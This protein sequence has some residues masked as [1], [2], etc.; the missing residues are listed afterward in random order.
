MR[1]SD[2]HKQ[3][4]RLRWRSLLPIV[5]AV[6]A[7][8]GGWYLGVLGIVACCGLAAGVSTF[9]MMRHTTRQQQ[10]REEHPRAATGDLACPQ[11]PAATDRPTQT[12]GQREDLSQ[13]EGLA[14]AP[15]QE[16]TAVEKSLNQ[17]DPNPQQQEREAPSEDEAPQAHDEH[18]AIDEMPRDRSDRHAFSFEAFTLEVLTADDPIEYLREFVQSVQGPHDQDEADGTDS[19]TPFEQFLAR[20]LEESGLLST[21]EEL[22]EVQMVWPRHSRL[23]YLRCAP[24]KVAYGAHLTLLRI[25][26][27][28][29]MGLFVSRYYQDDVEVDMPD[30]YRLQARIL[31]S[32]CAQAPDVETA[33]WGYLAMPWQSGHGPQELGEWALRQSIA[34]AIESAQVPYRLEASF[35]TNVASGDVAIQATY[36]PAHVF[37]RLAYAQDLGI[38]PTTAQMR[39][40]MASRYAASIGILLAARTFKA[41]SRVRR[42]WVS[43]VEETP[44]RHSCRYSVCFDRR[45]FSRLRMSAIGDPLHV[46]RDFGAPS[47]NDVDGL[48]PTEP[49]FYLE[50]ERF[51]PRMRH[52]LWHLSER[53]LGT[54]A[55]LMLGANRVSDLVIHEEL[56]RSIATDRILGMLQDSKQPNSAERSVRAILDVAHETSDLTVLDATERLV[57]KI[58]E[59][60][61]D[62]N[63]DEAVRDELMH[64]DALSRTVTRAQRLAQSGRHP[65][66]L[67]LLQDELGRIDRSGW[68]DDTKVIACRSFDS[69]AERCLYNRMN[70]ADGRSVVLVPDVYVVAHLFASALIVGSQ[71]PSPSL[72]EVACEHA[73]RALTVAPLS[74]VAHL[75]VVACLERSGDLEGASNQLISLLEVSHTPQAIGMAY[76]RMAGIQFL[77]DEYEACLACYLQSANTFAPLTPLIATECQMLV[78]QGVPFDLDMDEQK[79]EQTLRRHHIP[80]APTETTS[81]ALYE[82]AAASVDAEV[83]PVAKELLRILEMLTGDDV[84]RCMRQS[85][86]HEPDV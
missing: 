19:P 84:I 73:R 53:S 33:D 4:R 77:L 72:L 50:D 18:S 34:E 36:V 68:Y 7:V 58:V 69:F 38:V 57:E 31:R 71:E 44:S 55:M 10:R 64:G 46:L 6:A 22:P 49:C 21:D 79:I 26:A 41:N 1:R 83:F 78:S 2:T 25:E 80:L 74:P 59:G 67:K 81:Y 3:P 32:I 5:A 82:C 62:P 75:G 47:A 40:R 27:A 52:D 20:Q 24:G 56:P 37:P 13:T 86:E 9:V 28:L 15:G 76:Y 54:G 65:E 70:H 42:V 48:Q 23:F 61:V 8:V 35:R 14:D 17:A 51:C 16:G 43:C 45:A 63:D 30:L 11:V 66:A 29:N 39:S 85:I 12:E 60:K